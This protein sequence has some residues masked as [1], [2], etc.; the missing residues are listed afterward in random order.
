MGYTDLLAFICAPT[1]SQS[2]EV[3]QRCHPGKPKHWITRDADIQ[4]FWKSPIGRLALWG[5]RPIWEFKKLPHYWRLLT[6]QVGRRLRS[7]SF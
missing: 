4:V 2:V 1:L 6:W 3:W 5:V 7:V